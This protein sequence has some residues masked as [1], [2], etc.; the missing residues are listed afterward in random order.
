M[1][2]RSVSAPADGAFINLHAAESTVSFTSSAGGAD[3]D[4]DTW[5]SHSTDLSLVGGL[6]V[7]FAAP[8]VTFR[9]RTLDVVAGRDY[10]VNAD[11]IVVD[12]DNTEGA[13]DTTGSDTTAVAEET[14][15]FT[16]DGD[17]TFDSQATAGTGITVTTIDLA[18]TT[19][20]S[21]HIEADSGIL[22]VLALNADDDK[23]E[24]NSGGHTAFL[25]ETG[26]ADILSSDLVSI[27]AARSLQMQ[28]F[29]E[30]GI[31]V[32]AELGDFVVRAGGA[33]VY[34]E[35]SDFFNITADNP[36]TDTDTA[37][38]NFE[39]ANGISVETEIGGL[40]FEAYSPVPNSPTDNIL[41]S[42]GA[43]HGDV[44][45]DSTR[46]NIVTEAPLEVTFTSTDGSIDSQT[47]GHSAFASESDMTFTI[48]G[49]EFD[50]N[51]YRGVQVTAGSDGFPADLTW[52][53]GGQF[54][55]G[56]NGVID[57]HSVGPIAAGDVALALETQAGGM[58]FV[59]AN[60][61]D[62]RLTAR[63]D[64][65]F[66]GD[67]FLVTPATNDFYA[68]TVGGSID[69]FALLAGN[70]STQ[71]GP[72]EMITTTGSLGGA[73][74]LDALL[75]D[76][77][78][79]SG[80]SGSFSAEESIALQA[81]TG[82][83]LL[84]HDGRLTIAAEA[85]TSNI[86]MIAS[87]EISLVSVGTRYSDPQDGISFDAANNVEF[88]TTATERISFNSVNLFQIG[89]HTRPIVDINAGG[90]STQDGFVI[91]S[92]GGIFVQ[93]NRTLELSVTDD[94]EVTA[95]NAVT[96]TSGGPMLISSEQDVLLRSLL[97]V[98]RLSGDNLDMEATV[99]IEGT[100]S[101]VFSVGSTGRLPSHGV[102]LQAPL[103]EF[104][105]GGGME[106]ISHIVNGDVDETFTIT[107]SG[108][109]LV[110]GFSE[111]GSDT[112]I[113]FTANDA[114]LFQSRAA[115][116]VRSR[117]RDGAI[118]FSTQDTTDGDLFITT[119][120]ASDV[121][122][123]A[124]NEIGVHSFGP[125]TITSSNSKITLDANDT[126]PADDVSRG[127]IE[128]LATG[129]ITATATRNTLW[130]GEASVTIQ[131]TGTE[132]DVGGALSFSSTGEM[133]ITS[134]LDMTIENT[135]NEGGSITFT[136]QSNLD[137][138]SFNDEGSI[139]FA[140]DLDTSFTAARDVVYTTEGDFL[141]NIGEDV[142][143]TGN[144]IHP[145]NDY[146]V[147]INAENDDIEFR[148]LFGSLSF[149]GR[150]GL[151]VEAD[152]DFNLEADTSLSMVGA[153]GASLFA[154]GDVVFTAAEAR[155]EFKGNQGFTV[156][157]DALEMQAAGIDQL[158][159]H[160]VSLSSAGRLEVDT[161]LDDISATGVEGFY[162]SGSTVSFTT[163]N[164]N[165]EIDAENGHF[166]IDATDYVSFFAN[167]GITTSAD[168]NLV[169]QSGGYLF[170]DS[171]AEINL[172]G[173]EMLLQAT[174]TDAGV[175]G[176][177]AGALT[178]DAN[179]SIYAYSDETPGADVNIT[180]T[181]G[182][183]VID[184][185]DP[186][187]SPVLETSSST[188]PPTTETSTSPPTTTSI[189]RWAAPLPSHR[190]SSRPRPTSWA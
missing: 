139:T 70:F 59:T 93:S 188:S 113:S 170:V 52:T 115:L 61:G 22:N 66:T 53:S 120:V 81:E 155:V 157:A 38:I 134:T 36:T 129:D 74:T 24:F 17:I 149:F 187:S 189:S 19:E 130:T 154:A 181:L 82:I 5:L 150:D 119:Q 41:I 99:S 35:G 118:A 111:A 158:G 54:D 125:A 159:N 2:F 175:K 92:V 98:L 69:T 185:D 127:D 23:I 165:I 186:R 148:A 33:S 26:N 171:D 153:T 169:M 123:N 160:G 104:S 63:N 97:G 103:V 135:L 101:G 183:M 8:D 44:V 80:G 146:G 43:N 27:K 46:S 7:T 137:V 58:R 164:D 132:E 37:D 87:D 177:A 140:S 25:A 85:S 29:L 12:A 91:N 117:D 112:S 45:F 89:E 32:T 39:A 75:A 88:G 182:E 167:D 65:T 128:I 79:T 18:I 124:G 136:S 152:G 114:L 28:S 16:S 21:A 73:I 71:G 49:G 173:D 94:F 40:L 84:S 190:T 178:L 30:D 102:S 57:I 68:E 116:Q 60:T 90:S 131:T 145:S 156:T 108:D 176:F 151:E 6:D 13:V 133:S 126:D 143:I 3:I 122:F 20:Q 42:S 50:V 96:G 15:I 172:S 86:Q 163:E 174:G 162:V 144:G 180:T 10:I 55:A 14:V 47:F 107:A 48:G 110:K 67:N 78:F 77:T 179:G 141:A 138:E 56:A 76:I 168:E 34:F 166:L 106:W 4:A 62:I 64:Q 9:G 1:L 83:A 109:A 161:G 184:T 147:F 105:A 51:G 31:D 100:S 11:V 72:I 142:A 95:E 121:E